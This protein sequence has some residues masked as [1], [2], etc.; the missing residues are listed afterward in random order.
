[1]AYYT[2]ARSIYSDTAGF[3][4]GSNW[5]A[6]ALLISKVLRGDKR[7]ICHAMSL[8]SIKATSG[9]CRIYHNTHLRKGLGTLLAH[10]RGIKSGWFTILTQCAKHGGLVLSLQHICIANSTGRTTPQQFLVHSVLALQYY[11]YHLTKSNANNGIGD[12]AKSKSLLWWTSTTGGMAFF[13]TSSHSSNTTNVPYFE[14]NDKSLS[15]GDLHLQ[16]RTV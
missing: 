3:H 12:V 5:L 1:M 6:C 4:H 11:L 13:P 7:M 2:C 10:T 16:Y 9:L 8:G 15:Y 14:S